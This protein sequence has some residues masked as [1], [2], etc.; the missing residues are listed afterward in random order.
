MT[1]TII[2]D[3][4]ETNYTISDKGEVF[5]K[6]TGKIL[7]GTYARNEYH[8]VQLTIDGK[9]KTFMTHRLVAEMFL[10][11]PDNL[12]NVQHIDG[13]RYNNS[14][15]NLRWSHCIQREKDKSKEVEK[16]TID[17]SNVEWKP[18]IGFED[19]FLISNNGAVKSKIQEKLLRICRRNGYARYA[20]CGKMYSAHRLVYETFVGKI[21]E[22]M[23]IDHINGIRDDNRVENL[24]CITQSE[25][26]MN[27]QLNGHKCQHKVGKYEINSDVLIK[28]YPSFAA[29]AREMGVSPCAI[30]S[31]AKRNGT[32]CGYKWKEL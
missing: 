29:A 7:K 16:T 4:K 5:N 9:P 14:V 25:N 3:G 20:I 30:S 22:G 1:K 6:K 10:P 11:N 23:I 17:L 27:A 24:R 28:E 32:S 18:L 26:A 12:A 2:I 15:E 21:P 8:T 31:A 13:D 19:I